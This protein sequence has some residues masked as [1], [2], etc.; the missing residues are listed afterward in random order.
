[1]KGRLTPR[2]REVAL[3]VCAGRDTH[4]IADRLGI[5]VWTTKKH[6]SS[7]RHKIGANSM[8]DVSEA[9]ARYDAEE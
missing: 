8:R 9:L 7:L 6:I 2:E 4:G 1:M 5:S 3:E